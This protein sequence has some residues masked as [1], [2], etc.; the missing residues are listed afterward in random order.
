MRGGG[1]GGDVG[2]REGGVGWR[3]AVGG[4]QGPAELGW[5]VRR[6]PGGAGCV[7]GA[8]LGGATGADAATVA[9]FNAACRGLV[10]RYA[11]AWQ[12]VMARL[13]RWVDL[14]GA[15]RTM[16]PDYT[17]SVVWAFAELHRRGLVYEGDKVVA[18]CTRCQTP[19]S[20][21]ETRLDDAYRPRVDLA[22][23]VRYPRAADGAALLAWTTTPWTLPA[24]AA[25]AVHPVLTYVRME[26]PDGDAVWLAE[27]ACERYAAQLRG[28][29]A[30]ARVP[31]AKRATCSAMRCRIV[32]GRRCFHTRGTSGRDQKP[33]SACV[34]K[35]PVKN[36]KRA[37]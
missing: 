13:G 20:N 5:G 10:L 37:R 4:L 35:P 9:A 36:T 19:L 16:D 30:R 1:A 24:S 31:G 34:T 28:Y 17:E 15:Y 8:G 33:I 14:D 12:G 11:D 18:Y 2:E 25:L 22:V 7:E 26:A 3:W 29:V 21:F 27:A 6:A 23:T 32:S